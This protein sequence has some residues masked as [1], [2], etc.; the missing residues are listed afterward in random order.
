MYTQRDRFDDIDMDDI[1][2]MGCDVY[3]ERGSDSIMKKG[4]V[5]VKDNEM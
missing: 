4:F 5:K 1:I 2:E 3:F